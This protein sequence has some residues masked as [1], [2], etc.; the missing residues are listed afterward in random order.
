MPATRETCSAWGAEVFAPF[1][2]SS[3]IVFGRVAARSAAF[4]RTSASG[5]ASVLIGSAAGHDPQDV[6]VRAR[7]EL[8]E[9]MSNVLA[10]RA[11]EAAGTVVAT[12]EQL[13]RRRA[14]AVDPC[15]WGGPEARDA[16]QLW[17]AG[18]SLL[19][20]ADVL[21]PA[22][23]AF[24]H[25]RPPG[26]CQAVAS[27][28]STGVAAHPDAA[29]ATDHAAWEVFE[30]DLV[31]R[32]WYDAGPA[33]TMVSGEPGLP[34]VLEQLLHR[35]GLRLTVLRIPAPVAACCIVACLCTRAGHRQSFG[36]RCGPVGAQRQSIGKAAYEA[37]MV[38][39]SMNTPVARSAWLH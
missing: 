13:R 14:P 18:Q 17:V 21:V 38:R 25:H 33:P 19:T 6:A 29:A 30:R 20:G 4:G 5:G 7:G 39:W 15:H 35:L 27:A 32:S 11:A 9:R 26:G 22:G 3:Q 12:F 36:A 1:P 28:G 34:T 10:G 31:R 24:L 16:S 2:E 23:A 37:L 8:L